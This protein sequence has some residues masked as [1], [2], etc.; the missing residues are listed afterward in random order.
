MEKFYKLKFHNG[1]EREYLDLIDE[2]LRDSRTLI[3]EEWL[4]FTMVNH[5]LKHSKLLEKVKER[6][7]DASKDDPIIKKPYQTIRPILESKLDRVEQHQNREDAV[8]G[9]GSP[10]AG[11]LKS[12]K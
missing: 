6:Y 10:A 11:A 12:K 2:F 5:C 8:A 4:D 1:K 7:D 3:P 9:F